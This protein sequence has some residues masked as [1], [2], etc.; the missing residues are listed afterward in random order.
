MMSESRKRNSLCLCFLFLG[1][2]IGISF[3]AEF[4][5]NHIRFWVNPIG[6]L[7]FIPEQG[8]TIEWYRLSADA[9]LMNIK[10]YGNAPCVGGT[11][12]CTIADIP[13]TTVYTYSCSANDDP[14]FTCNDPQGGPTSPTGD[15]EVVGFFVK[16]ADLFRHIA[17]RIDQIF[18]DR[19]TH[20]RPPGFVQNLHGVTQDGVGSAPTNQAGEV[21]TRTQGIAA[22]VS[23][24][25][26]SDPPG[27]ATHV[28]VPQQSSAPDTPIQATVGQL[29]QWTTSLASSFTIKMDDPST[30]SPSV[31]TLGP[32]GI[33]KVA[34]TGTYTA[35]VTG[36]NTVKACTS[37][38]EKIIAP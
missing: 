38:P 8:D 20:A 35:T 23:C 7:S 4:R 33:C 1:I 29:I 2:L 21:S 28:Y 24:N 32:G 9:P 25:A 18:F 14:S 36:S 22:T 11:N 31:S 12:P 5:P 30:C 37:T 16:V 17:G 19:S 6:N 34:K 15:I 3:D 13:Q 10:F 27:G 26:S